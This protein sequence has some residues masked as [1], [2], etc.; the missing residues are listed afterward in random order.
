MAIDFHAFICRSLQSKSLQLKSLDLVVA[1][2]FLHLDLLLVAMLLQLLRTALLGGVLALTAMCLGA[3][4]LDS[5]LLDLVTKFTANNLAVRSVGELLSLLGLSSALHFAHLLGLE[6]A[7]L[8]LLGLREP[9]SELLTEP[10]VV[11]AAHLCSNHSWSFIAVL[12]W[13]R[14][15]HSALAITIPRLH[16][17][18]IKVACLLAHHVVDHGLLVLAALTIKLDALEVIEG[19]NSDVESGVANPLIHDGAKLRIRVFH[20]S[21]IF[22]LFFQTTDQFVDV[23]ACLL[24]G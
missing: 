3:D 5:L 12:N 10:G 7:V 4:R 21:L 20:Y 2:L 18:A 23:E 24:I 17:P 13:Y 6:V 22:H 19:V 15:A 14:S 16:L 9:I 1:D 8:L 11:W